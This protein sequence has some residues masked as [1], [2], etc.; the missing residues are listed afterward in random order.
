MSEPKYCSLLWAHISNEPLGHVR[1]CCIAKERVKDNDGN[2]FTLGST[3]VREIFHSDFYKKLRQDIREGKLPENCEPC[4]REEDNGKKSKRQ[5]YNEYAEWRFDPID[6]SKE[7]DMPQDMQL[8]LSTTCNLK[9]RSC[10]PNYSSKWVKEADARGLPY[11]KETVTVPMDDQERSKFWTEID[12]W[13]PH[14]R[15]LEIMGGEPLYMK[16]FKSFANK[17]I[18]QNIAPKVGLSFSTNGTMAGG[19]FFQKIT[20]NFK[21][22][23]FNISIDAAEKKR[24]DYLRHGADWNEVAENLDIIHNMLDQGNV[25]AGITCTVTALNLMYLAE[26]HEEF[27]KRWPKFHIFHNIANLPSWYNPNVF[28]NEMKEEIVKPLREGLENNV[29]KTDHAVSEITGII[30]HS[31]AP[32]EDVI[33]PYG[34]QPT[35]TVENEIAVR[36]NMFRKQVVAGDEYRKE[37]FRDVFPELWEIIKDDFFYSKLYERAK[38][39][40]MYGAIDKGTF[41]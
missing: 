12:D 35:D 28:P 30:N 8:I 3:S 26:M 20:E 14:I 40:P 32:R 18:D 4:W 16:E 7:P 39:D 13:L 1:T 38:A 27:Y 41:I 5:I 2:D 11:Y 6:Y 37:D 9:C 34:N 10:N 25:F 33:R 21:T 31:I 23:S 15:N 19:D 17:L 36:W 29:F 24:F 22:V